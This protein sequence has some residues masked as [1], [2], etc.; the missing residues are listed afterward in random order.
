M[1]SELHLNDQ[2]VYEKEITITNYKGN[3][4][5]D[6]NEIKEFIKVTIQ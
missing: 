4:N 2:E 6:D 5:E 3:T 1:V